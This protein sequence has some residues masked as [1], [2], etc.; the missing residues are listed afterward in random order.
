MGAAPGNNP[1]RAW[2]TRDWSRFFLSKTKER[3][4]K[5]S[6]ATPW[7]A[8]FFLME[9]RC[10]SLG[11]RVSSCLCLPLLWL[12]LFARSPQL[13]LARLSPSP[14][15]LSRSSLHP[16]PSPFAAPS[17]RLSALAPAPLSS[18]RGSALGLPGDW[19]RGARAPRSS[20]TLQRWHGARRWRP[21]TLA[22][23]RARPPAVPGLT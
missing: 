23:R 22:E 6:F 14:L 8:H 10:P 15:P 7:P 16:P 11:A 1:A 18:A 9:F 5:P 2:R 12:S 19:R 21:G 3:F 13:S 17:P 4:K 20:D